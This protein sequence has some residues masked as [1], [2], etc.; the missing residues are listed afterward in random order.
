MWLLL[1]C[2]YTIH[3]IRKKH[4]K[5]YWFSLKKKYL[6]LI[7]FGMSIFGTTGHQTTV[8]YSTSPNVC[9]CTTWEKPNKWNRIKMQYFVGFVSEGSAEA[10]NGCGRKSDNPSSSYNQKVRDFF[11]QTR[12]TGCIMRIIHLTI[13]VSLV[14]APKLQTNKR[15]K[16]QTISAQTFPTTRVTNVKTWKEQRSKLTCTTYYVTWATLVRVSPMVVSRSQYVE[17]TA[18]FCTQP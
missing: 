2:S 18:R 9:F 16:K 6:I 7:I 14:L 3:C 1:L 4:H 17:L 10:D 15:R 8:Q 13:S 5:P 12:C 11:F